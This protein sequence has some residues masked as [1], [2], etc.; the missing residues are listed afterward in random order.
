MSESHAAGETDPGRAR[1]TLVAGAVLLV[2]TLAAFWPVVVGDRSFFHYDLFYEHLP[3]W[4]AAQRSLLSGASPFWLDGEYCGHPPLFVQ[5]TPLFYPLT[6]PLLATGAPVHRLADLFSLFHFWLAGMAAF[7]LLREETGSAAASLFGGIAWMLSARMIQSALWPNAVAVSAL[8]PLLLLGI[9]RIGR[10]KRRGGVL[11]AAL[12]G[13]LALLAARPH[14]LLAAAPLVCAFAAVAILSAASRRRACF[15]LA[16]AAVLAAAL[17]APSVLPTTALLPETSRSEGMPSDLPDLQPLSQGRELD[18]VFLPV[19]G[20]ERWPET[21]A[22]A[23]AAVCAL[24]LSGIYLLLRRRGPFPRAVFLG[25]ALGGVVG[26][27]L[28]FGASGPYRVLSKLPLLRGFRVPER[29]LFSWSLA[30]ALGSALALAHWLKTG[31]R[32]RWLGTASVALLAAD[33]LVHARRSAPTA[34]SA[35]YETEPAI[36]GELRRHLGVDALGFPRRYASLADPINPVYYSDS[37][38]LVMTRDF[39]PLRLALGMRFG[40]EAVNGYGPTLRRSEELAS[41]ANERAL[42]LCGVGAVVVSAP[43]SRTDPP[44]QARRPVLRDFAALPRAI[45]LPEARIVDPAASLR[46]ALSPTLDP[47]RTAILEEG[48][49]MSRGPAW[50]EGAVSLRLVSRAPGRIVLDTAVPDRAVLVVFDTWEAG[51]R[52]KVDGRPEVVGRA[53]GAFRGV[54]LPAGRHRV[55][56]AYVPRGLKEGAALGFV[57]ALGAVLAA[58]RL[59]AGP[60]I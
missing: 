51:W 19:D 38:L 33:L 8:V 18:M 53:D 20:R 28:A 1:S 43:P 42:E 58:L 36:V 54:R 31:N 32:G 48:E 49:P 29:F 30:L 40:L 16:V 45:L 37:D 17:G 12:S 26:L 34:P 2:L 56:L 7:L 52:A 11:L 46:A 5:E 6:V 23:G 9:V 14:V 27:V 3:V 13:G 39:E 57:G 24:F 47:R 22:Y 44:R 59:P 41:A 50:D 10:G 15:D 55:E 4:E 25:A 21:A 60:R 35:V